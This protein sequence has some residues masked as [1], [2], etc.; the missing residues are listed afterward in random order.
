KELIE[1]L[2]KH[3]F[4]A[5]QPETQTFVSFIEEQL[6]SYN[7]DNQKKYI[8]L[9][10]WVRN[11]RPSMKLTDW[12]ERTLDEFQLFLA[13]SSS[14]NSQN[15][16][17]KMLQRVSTILTKGL[18]YNLLTFNQHPFKCGYRLKHGKPKDIKLEPDQLKRLWE[19]RND[20]SHRS[21]REAIQAWFLSF[22]MDGTRASDVITLKHSQI[23]NGVISIK[24]QKTQKPI[25]IS[26]STRLDQLLNE[27]P[28][29]KTYIL[30]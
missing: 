20:F 19:A 16:I 10:N 29:T 23:K 22:Y 8:T 28:S 26:I 15:T 7:E 21:Y 18:R 11:F 27:L 1:H 25:T 24:Q 14:I 9:A 30:P 3:G 13:N 12:D 17:A 2:R 4:T 5:P 6:P